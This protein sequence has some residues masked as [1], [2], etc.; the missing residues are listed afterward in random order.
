MK[1]KRKLLV[2]SSLVACSAIATVALVGSV[3]SSLFSAGAATGETHEF[4]LDHSNYVAESAHFTGYGY[5]YQIKGTSKHHGDFF[6]VDEVT[7]AYGKYNSQG[8][9]CEVYFGGS[10]YIVKANVDAWE[11]SAQ[12]IFR[13]NFKG[14]TQINSCTYVYTVDGTEYENIPYIDEEE[15][16]IYEVISSPYTAKSYISLKSITV[17]Y[18]C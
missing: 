9:D 6:S 11:A 15:N 3:N 18:S 2:L 12:I 13:F 5:E 17:S 4:T 7:S 14:I 16:Y 10:D 1:S 8:T